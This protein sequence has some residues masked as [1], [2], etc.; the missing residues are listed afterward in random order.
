MGMLDVDE[1]G[2]K[3]EAKSRIES[4]AKCAIEE[5]VGGGVRPQ[6]EPRQWQLF[7]EW[8]VRLCMGR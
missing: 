6:A 1:R 3:C 2:K 7:G 5:M 8:R 4:V